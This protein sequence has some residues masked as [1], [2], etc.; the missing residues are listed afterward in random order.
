QGISIQEW[1]EKTRPTIVNGDEAVPLKFERQSI[2]K[3][4]SDAVVDEDQVKK[5]LSELGLSEA[6]QNEESISAIRETLAMFQ[7]EFNE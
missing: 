6:Y 4:E 2:P 1:F 7:S 5:A 3:F